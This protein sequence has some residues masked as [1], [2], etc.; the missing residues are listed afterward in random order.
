MAALDKL[1][2]FFKRPK[3]EAKGG[4]KAAERPET[5]ASEKKREEGA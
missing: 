3:S 1:K 5:K 4:K 2:A